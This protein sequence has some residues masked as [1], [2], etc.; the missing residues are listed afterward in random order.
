[1]E[2][3]NMN[4]TEEINVIATEGANSESTKTGSAGAALATLGILAAAGYGAGKLIECGVKKLAPKVKGLFKK[5]Q[6][7]AIDIID[8]AEIV[9]AEGKE[10]TK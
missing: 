10:V 3:E 2:T 8:A 9:D 5:K 6:D 1:M 4:V 7:D